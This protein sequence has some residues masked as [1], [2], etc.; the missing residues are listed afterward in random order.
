MQCAGWRVVFQLPNEGAH[1]L[2]CP[3]TGHLAHQL[4]WGECE[5]QCCAGWRGGVTARRHPPDQDLDAQ[6]LA[7]PAPGP[8]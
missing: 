7:E 1:L 6:P 4:P 8:R 3:A 5:P 2:L